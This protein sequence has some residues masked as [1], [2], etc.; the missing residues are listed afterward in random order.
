MLASARLGNHARLAHAA[1]EQ[2]LADR[3]VDLVCAGVIQVLALQI[4]LRT[5]EL[6]AH[7]RR[8]IDGA[9][10]ADVVRELG[11]KLGHESRIAAHFGVRLLQLIERMDQCLGDEGAAIGAEMPP[12]I[13]LLVVQHERGPVFRLRYQRCGHRPLAPP[14]RTGESPRHP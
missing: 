3:V 2:R 13:G 6:A 4:D 10:P 1:R 9:G 11:M 7:A 12:C 8:V 5:A 14:H